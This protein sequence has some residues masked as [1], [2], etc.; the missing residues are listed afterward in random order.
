[1]SE[2]KTKFKVEKCDEFACPLF[3]AGH[4]GS[5]MC[6]ADSKRRD[7]S[8]NQGKP[9]EWCPLRSGPVTIRFK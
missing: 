4:M 6:Q 7:L 9:P 3:H 5:Q 8:T 1:M 2:V